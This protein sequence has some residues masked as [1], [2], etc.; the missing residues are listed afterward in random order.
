MSE[1]CSSIPLKLQTTYIPHPSLKKQMTHKKNQKRFLHTYTCM[2]TYTQTH[3]YAQAHISLDI[4]YLLWSHGKHKLLILQQTWT[5]C[6]VTYQVGKWLK[7][8]AADVVV[9]AHC[10]DPRVQQRGVQMFKQHK[11][12]L[13]FDLNLTKIY[14]PMK[15]IESYL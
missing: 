8:P 9:T 15:K 5:A 11:H 6:V 10:Q 12:T 1:R 13:V 4:C 7:L 2:H 14:Q 3:T